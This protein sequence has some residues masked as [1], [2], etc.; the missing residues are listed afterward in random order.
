M[1][2]SHSSAGSSVPL[3]QRLRLPRIQGSIP[4]I[5]SKALKKSAPLIILNI[6]GSESDGPGL[7][8][9]TRTVPSGV[10]SLVQS[11]RPVVG[12]NAPKNIL[13][14]PATP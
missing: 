12:S 1:P 10:P 11:S 14:F 4:V 2:S 6:L 5:G 13:P 8:S 7:M 9:A 3:P